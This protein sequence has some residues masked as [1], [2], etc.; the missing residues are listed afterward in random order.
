MKRTIINILKVSRLANTFRKNE[1][2]DIDLNPS[3]HLYIHY[4]CK[5]E[6]CKQDELI[7]FFH[8]D[9]TTVTHQLNE[10]E[11]GGYIIRGVD[12]KDRRSRLIYPTDKAKQIDPIVHNA[13]LQFEDKILEDLTDEEKEILDTLTQKIALKAIEVIDRQGESL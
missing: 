2:K 7:K 10:L 11:K 1:L 4:V 9:K 8:L 6:G 13:L 5:H 3:L 12:N